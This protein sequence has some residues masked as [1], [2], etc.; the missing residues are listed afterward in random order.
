M[1]IQTAQGYVDRFG[2]KFH[3]MVTDPKVSLLALQEKYGVSRSTLVYVR[4]SLNGTT[5]KKFLRN[6]V[7]TPEMITMF[8]S[9][10]Y[11]R[12]I[13][14]RLGMT[15]N[16]VNNHRRKY[17]PNTKIK[18]L[19]FDGPTV[20]LLKSDLPVKDIARALKVGAPAVYK[21]RNDLMHRKTSTYNRRPLTAD[22]VAR[23][24]ACPDPQTA[25]RETGVN[26]FTT[27]GLFVRRQIMAGDEK[28]VTRRSK[29]A[30]RFPTDPT[31]WAARTQKQIIKQLGVSP[32]AVWYHAV[33]RGYT[34]KGMQKIEA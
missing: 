32:G 16:Q 17:R 3:A 9:E 33:T 5:P 26:I 30:D 24:Y 11:N 8:K 20:A 25:A 19:R 14:E 6:L 4:H 21:N 18:S 31:W 2:P 13:A 10:L 12:E 23:V 15:V 29:L 7:I 34:Y 22:L 1:N 27:R 28:A